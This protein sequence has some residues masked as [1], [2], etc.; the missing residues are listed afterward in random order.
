MSAAQSSS[1]AACTQVNTKVE[2]E[3]PHPKSKSK[4]KSA[5]GCMSPQQPAAPKWRRVPEPKDRDTTTPAQLAEIAASAPSLAQRQEQA[6]QRDA[7][8]AQR[9]LLLSGQPL[10][11]QG[12]GLTFDDGDGAADAASDAVPSVAD[13]LSVFDKPAAFLTTPADANA[14]PRFDSSVDFSA[15]AVA[16]LTRRRATIVRRMVL[17]YSMHMY[18]VLQRAKGKVRARYV[19]A[20]EECPVVQGPALPAAIGFSSNRVA[21]VAGG[22]TAGDREGRFEAT[23]IDQRAHGHNDLGLKDFCMPCVSGRGALDL[24]RIPCAFGCEGCR[25]TGFDMQT[26]AEVNE[27]V[28]RVHKAGNPDATA[29]EVKAAGAEGVQRTLELI[30]LGEQAAAIGGR[31]SCNNWRCMVASGILLEEHRAKWVASK[32]YANFNNGNKRHHSKELFLRNI[33]LVREMHLAGELTEEQ[34]ATAMLD[35]SQSTFWTESRQREF[36]GVAIVLAQRAQDMGYPLIGRDAKQAFIARMGEVPSNFINTVLRDHVLSDAFG[37]TMD[38]KPAGNS[39]MWT[40]VLTDLLKQTFPDALTTAHA[41]MLHQT[42]R[43]YGSHVDQHGVPRHEV[44]LMDLES[45]VKSQLFDG[46]QGFH[47]VVAPYFKAAHQHKLKLLFDSAAAAVAEGG[48]V[49]AAIKANAR[50]MGLVTAGQKAEFERMVSLH[51]NTRERTT[52]LIPSAG[53]GVKFPYAPADNFLREP[54]NAVVWSKTVAALRCLNVDDPDV[55]ASSFLVDYK[56]PRQGGSWGFT[57]KA[58]KR[59]SDP[60]RTKSETARR[61]A[62][63]FDRNACAGYGTSLGAARRARDATVLDFEMLRGSMSGIG[64]RVYDPTD[65]ELSCSAAAYQEKHRL[66]CANRMLSALRNL[67]EEIRSISVETLSGIE[68][69]LPT[70]SSRVTTVDGVGWNDLEGEY[71]I[72]QRAKELSDAHA[73]LN[74][75]EEKWRHHRAA[76]FPT[77]DEVEVLLAHAELMLEAQAWQGVPFQDPKLGLVRRYTADMQRYLA[78]LVSAVRGVDAPMP[79]TLAKDIVRTKPVWNRK[80]EGAPPPRD[81]AEAKHFATY[82]AVDQLALANVTSNYEQLVADG[83]IDGASFS[84]QDYL[85]CDAAHY[86]Q[87]AKVQRNRVKRRW[88]EQTQTPGGVWHCANPA[89]VAA[90]ARWSPGLGDHTCRCATPK[91]FDAY[92]KAMRIPDAHLWPTIESERDRFARQYMIR[93]QAD[94]DRLK[95]IVC[96]TDDDT[97]KMSEVSYELEVLRAQGVCA[98]QQIEA[99]ARKDKEAAKLYTR[100]KEL[101]RK[102]ATSKGR[103]SQE[104]HAEALNKLLHVTPRTVSRFVKGIVDSQ[105]EPLHKAFDAEV[106]RMTGNNAQTYCRQRTHLTGA[107]GSLFGGRDER[108]AT[109]NAE[110]NGLLGTKPAPSSAAPAADVSAED[111]TILNPLRQTSEMSDAE[112]DDDD[113]EQ[114]TEEER[115]SKRLKRQGARLDDAAQERQAEAEY[116]D[117][118]EAEGMGIEQPQ[119]DDA[120]SAF[121]RTK[122]APLG[123]DEVLALLAEIPRVQLKRPTK[124]KDKDEEA[125]SAAGTSKAPPKSKSSGRK[126][127]GKPTRLHK[128]VAGQLKRGVGQMT[129]DEV[130]LSSPKVVKRFNPHYAALEAARLKRARDARDAAQSTEADAPA[131]NT[132]AKLAVAEP[133]PAPA[134]APAPAPIHAPTDDE[135]SDGEAS[136]WTDSEAE[137]DEWSD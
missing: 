87:M 34:V 25:E 19:L 136:V 80:K 119:R 40:T 16:Q 49:V 27:Q 48:D 22:E 41:D 114:Q 70:T 77:E 23:D 110:F 36:Y 86:W 89:C 38:F 112:D 83:I 118:L 42:W 37:H 127:K 72:M 5:S 73:Y 91:S 13:M 103:F 117:A 8:A 122:D 43:H 55:F 92:L 132:K 61:R 52:A 26:L 54:Q 53:D 64:L 99:R 121:A 50:C 95:R 133:T 32:Q 51:K 129:T 123:E 30:A 1:L 2:S 57:I 69:G 137:D 85:L 116:D 62:D 28:Q 113:D 71:A 98:V 20:G 79:E 93:E 90:H 135:W 131:R 82:D 59:V 68:L 101:E 88:W 124:D 84:L 66:A 44:D 96:R 21:A 18:I 94:V 67:C 65:D 10:A 125:T 105:T 109:M 58:A 9:Q 35:I 120:E 126:G 78:S 7:E 14:P 46:A 76:L 29:A 128:R 102:F 107:D 100:M 4:S 115:L 39:K 11:T 45:N 108:V 106:K 134:P 97:E 56:W 63:T 17:L 104:L 60:Y 130:E 31:V 74:R 6:A 24:S 47:S 15:E 12:Y 33:V 75:F 3:T 111:E 81:E